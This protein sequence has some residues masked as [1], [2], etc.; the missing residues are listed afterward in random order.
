MT[1]RLKC[2]FF[3][4]FILS[5]CAFGGSVPLSAQ[6]S[7]QT[8]SS[9]STSYFITPSLPPTIL[10]PVGNSYY[11]VMR[12]G[13]GSSIIQDAALSPLRYQGLAALGGLE[14]RAYENNIFLSI[15]GDVQF[16][17]TSPTIGNDLSPGQITS[18]QILPL[19]MLGFRLV[20]EELTALR[21]Y[22]GATAQ[23]VSHLKIQSAF[24]NSA[25]A[26]D[27]YSA[28]GVFGRVEKDFSLFGK[29]FR[30]SSNLSLPLFGLASRPSYSTTTRY[31]ASGSANPLSIFSELRF[32][33]FASFPLV[34]FR[35]SLEFMLSSGNFITLNY[36]WDFYS[37]NYYNKVQSARHGVSLG[38]LFKF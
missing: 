38:L 31:P 11:L 15:G 9:S 19:T 7:S 35:N 26:T 33:T 24:G 29:A 34:S 21:V 37:Y 30:A 10:P 28:V 18:V 17:I 8:T 36:D 25:L 1:H 2:L 6:D 5:L 20:N 13:S 12:L 22:G 4:L 27:G 32:V 16:S 14:Y 23:G 3:K